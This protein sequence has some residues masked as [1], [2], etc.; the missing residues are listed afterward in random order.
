VTTSGSTRETTTRVRG[1]Q[2]D[3]LAE[4]DRIFRI[5]F[6]TFLGLPDPAT[7]FGDADYVRT[8]WGANPEAALVAE[9]G[10]ELVGS[11]FITEWGSVGFFGPLTIRPDFWDRGIAQRL[12][13]PTLDRLRMRVRHAGLFTFAQSP[14]HAGLYQKYGFWP[15]YLTALMARQVAQKRPAK[16]WTRFSELSPQSRQACLKECAQLTGEIYEGLDL[17]REIRA[18][19]GQNL[20]DTILL[21]E[22]DTLVGLAVC[23]CGAGS[24]AGTGTCYVKFGAARPGPDAARRFDRLVDACDAFAAHRG[25][26]RLLAGMNM[27]RLEA[28]QR[29]LASGFRTDMQGVAMEWSDDVGYNRRDVFIID[30]WR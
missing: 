9:V 28:Y 20:G 3:D 23:H 5:A 19:A 24:E 13:E 7:C 22:D 14:K 25:L 15:R 11:N 18:V 4:A 29:L 30:D 27:A 26:G 16:S 12:L 21:R 17:S 8:R 2:K 6:G 1:L 10:G